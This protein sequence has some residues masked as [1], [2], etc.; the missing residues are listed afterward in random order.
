M[1]SP[2]PRVILK[3]RDSATLP[4]AD[5]IGGDIDRQTGGAWTALQRQFPGVR[6]RRLYRTVSQK[7]L[8][9]LVQRAVASDP[10]YR[11]PNFFAYYVVAFPDAFD[12]QD[13]ASVLARW[14]LVEFAYPERAASTP[15]G[16][17]LNPTSYALNHLQGYEDPAPRGI[18]ARCAWGIPGGDGYGQRVIDLEVGWTL[19]HD[20]FV[21][22]NPQLLF[23]AIDPAEC[24]HGTSVLAV[25]CARDG[26]AGILGV[27]P[28]VDSVN[29]VSYLLNGMVAASNIPDAIVAATQ[30][31][32]VGHVLVLEVELGFLPC[33]IDP[34]CYAPIRL[35]TALGIAVVEAAGNGGQDLDTWLDSAGHPILFRDPNN[36]W[37][38]DSRAIIVAAAT[39]GLPHRRTA[40]SNYGTRIDCYAWGDNVTT[41]SSA[42]AG[43]TSSHTVPPEFKN[44]S[45]ATA[46]VAGAALSV[47]GMVEAA[48]GARLPP[49]LLQA[50]LRQGTG[51]VDAIGIMPDLCAIA[52]SIER[53][54]TTLPQAP[55]NLRIQK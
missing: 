8:N 33:E 55:T 41:A 1:P 18:D 6:I 46:I 10:T 30:Q 53:I 4:Y 39:S 49:A 38:L 29:V 45:A 40:S 15:A 20:D 17:G 21:V 12:A 54:V 7:E 26:P 27:A 2:I 28:N 9:D 31:L 42:N 37:F 24:S 36:T 44:T 22:H 34:S 47:Q 11:P 3:F 23:G 43:D 51:S 16:G 35:A 13:V 50:A 14:P 48:T 32:S 5:D 25:I 52:A 19:N